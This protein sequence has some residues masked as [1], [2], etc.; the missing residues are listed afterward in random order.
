M[1]LMD[2]IK[3]VV[4]GNKKTITDAVDKGAD[5]VES[6]TPDSIDPHVEKGAEAV[7]DIVNKVDE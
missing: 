1:G 4:G 2:S 6:K 5:L 3:G 7:K